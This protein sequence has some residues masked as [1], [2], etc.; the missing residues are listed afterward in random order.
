MSVVILFFFF[1]QAE[2]GI[3]DWSV[4]GVQTCA[5][6]ICRVE[7]I[8]IETELN[9]QVLDSVFAFANYTWNRPEIKDGP[10]PAD[11]GNSVPFT[12]AD[13]FNLVVHVCL[14]RLSFLDLWCLFSYAVGLWSEAYERG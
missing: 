3:R 11:N 1:F 5:L 13:S 4:T 7:S 8:G 14:Y 2:D 10:E 9:Y 12:N 6:P